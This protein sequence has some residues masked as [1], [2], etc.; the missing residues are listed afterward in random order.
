MKSNSRQFM[1]VVLALLTVI[2]GSVELRAQVG[3][4]RVL[5]DFSTVDGW[6]AHP[7]DGTSLTIRSDV[8][9]IGGAMRLDFD[10]HG[11]GGYVIARKAL[12]ITFPANY[13]L[14]FR[15]RGNA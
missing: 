9:D 15:I 3:T 1:S 12:P 5:D 4:P 7:S 11:G 2:A 8:G 13:D 10:F 6:T 14:S